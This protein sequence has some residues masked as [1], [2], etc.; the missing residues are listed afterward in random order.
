MWYKKIIRTVARN[1]DNLTE[2]EQLKKQKRQVQVSVT[3]SS[4]MPAD[5]RVSTEID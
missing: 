4:N 5:S 1:I 3:E 2:L